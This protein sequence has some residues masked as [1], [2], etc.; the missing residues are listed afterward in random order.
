MTKLRKVLATAAALIL[1]GGYTVYQ[2]IQEAGTTHEMSMSEWCANVAHRSNT[3]LIETWHLAIPNG[4]SIPQAWPDEPDGRVLGVCNAGT[5]EFGASQGHECNYTYTYS[6][7]TLVNGYRLYTI[8]SHPYIAGGWR[9]WAKV[10]DSEPFGSRV[11]WWGD[12]LSD[13]M[14]ACIRSPDMTDSQCLA[15][16]EM[17][18]KC[19]FLPDG[20]ACRYGTQLGTGDACPYA[21]IVT[22]VTNCLGEPTDPPWCASYQMPAIYPCTVYRGAGSER[23]D[24]ARVWTDEEMDEL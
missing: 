16:L 19:V 10:T 17:D 6:A 7:S 3:Q 21:E 24:A 11:Y 14:V 23:T 5:C 15:L 20:S 1:G 4:T 18:T 13:P 8:R 22:Y 9:A 2:A 12:S